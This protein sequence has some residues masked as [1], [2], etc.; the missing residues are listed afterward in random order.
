MEE[1]Y[2]RSLDEYFCENYSDYAAI[3]AIEGYRM[4]DLIMIG[5]D[6]NVSRKENELMR[7][8]RQPNAAELLAIFK[9]NLGDTSFT[10]GFSFVSFPERI[11]DFFRK[12]TF[13]KLLPVVLKKQEETPQSAGAKLEIEPKIWEK[14]VKGKLYPEK[15]TILA[16]AL[17]SRMTLQDAVNLLAV[18]GFTLNKDNVRDVV[19]EYLLNHKIFNEKMRDNCLAEYKIE[20][21]PIKHG[22]DGADSRL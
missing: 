2:I 18:C 14:I 11:K 3:T 16:L 5:K 21:L 19:V 17:S 13:A 1:E 10:F 9:G 7:L 15:N 6:G 12:H 8:S 20:N 22:E 4:P